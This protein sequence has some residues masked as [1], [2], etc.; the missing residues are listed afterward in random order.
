MTANNIAVPN[1]TISKC[2]WV[3][4]DGSNVPVT[5]RKDRNKSTWF[6]AKPRAYPK[7][8]IPISAIVAVRILSD[9]TATILG[10]DIW[11]S[12]PIKSNGSLIAASYNNET[13]KPRI[14]ITNDTIRF[15]LQIN[16][17]MFYILRLTDCRRL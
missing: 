13:I 5:I 16:I 2:P 4:I 1:C 11:L 7:G 3:I 10:K 9:H 12:L 6:K 17:A 8:A 14:S 15:Q